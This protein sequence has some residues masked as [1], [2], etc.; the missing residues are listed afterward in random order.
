MRNSTSLKMLKKL[1]LKFIRPDLNSAFDIHDCQGIKLLK[2]LHLALKHLNYH[3]F[4]HYF[5]DCVNR[6]CSFGHDIE[7][8]TNFFLHCSHYNSSVIRQKGESQNGGNKKTK[9]AKFSDKKTF[10]TPWYAHVRLP[11]FGDW[12]FCFITD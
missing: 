5:Q 1:T 10:L 8:T 4:R 9:H 6:I 2:R 11:L 3:K 12:P 7:T